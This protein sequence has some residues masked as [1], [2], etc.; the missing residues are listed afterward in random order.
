MRPLVTLLTSEQIGT[1]VI[2]KSA[3]IVPVFLLMLPIH[4]M[5]DPWPKFC[6]SCGTYL[7]ISPILFIIISPQSLHFRLHSFHRIVRSRGLQPILLPLSSLDASYAARNVSLHL[8]V[9]Q[10]GRESDHGTS[11]F[12]DFAVLSLHCRFV[13]TEPLVDCCPALCLSSHCAGLTLCQVFVRARH[14]WP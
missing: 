4:S 5:I 13:V 14:C 10:C 1:T 11:P 9:L 2:F 12:G 6:I 7:H 8:I 3:C